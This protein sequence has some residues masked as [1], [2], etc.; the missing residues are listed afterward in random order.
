M[1]QNAFGFQNHF[2]EMLSVTSYYIGHF[3]LLSGLWLSCVFATDTYWHELPATKGGNV[4]ELNCLLESHLFQRL[5]TA[6]LERGERLLV[7]L[8]QTR[9]RNRLISIFFS[10][11]GPSTLLKVCSTSTIYNIYSL[12]GCFTCKRFF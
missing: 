2:M 11:I 10:T 7:L 4:A 9:C 8:C 12:Q 3:S 6:T 5:T 1:Q